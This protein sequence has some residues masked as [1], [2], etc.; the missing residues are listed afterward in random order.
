MGLPT[1]QGSLPGVMGRGLREG[2]KPKLVAL[3]SPLPSPYST[4]TMGSSEELGT[5][6]AI[7]EVGGSLLLSERP[8]CPAKRPAGVK[9][10]IRHNILKIFNDCVSPMNKLLRSRVA[11]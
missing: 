11:R 3:W 7:E 10:Y 8:V 1:S 2:R 4:H 9:P 5:A 6:R